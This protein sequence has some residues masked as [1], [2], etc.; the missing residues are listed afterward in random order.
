[1]TAPAVG[2][3]LFVSERIIVAPTVGIFHRVRGNGQSHEGDVIDRGHVVGIVQ[4]LGTSTPVRSPFD[5][6]LVA[7]LALEGER[8]RP[9]QPVAWLRSNE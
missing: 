7:I 3:T 5:G 4:S 1:M 9:G 6:M 8:V 2:E